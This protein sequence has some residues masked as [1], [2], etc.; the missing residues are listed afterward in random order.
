MSTDDAGDGMSTDDGRQETGLARIAFR[1]RDKPQAFLAR[2]IPFRIE[3]GGEEAVVAPGEP[4]MVPRG[5]VVVTAVVPYGRSRRFELTTGNDDVLEIPEDAGAIA[6][7][8][9]P[10]QEPTGQ[11]TGV[12]AVTGALAFN[13]SRW[14]QAP[15]PL[16]ESTG[17]RFERAGDLVRISSEGSPSAPARLVMA[18]KTTPAREMA[19]PLVAPGESAVINLAARRSWGAR[20]SLVPDELPPRLLLAYL[21]AGEYDIAGTMAR[22]LARAYGEAGTIRWAAPSFA[23]LIIGYA[24]A[25]NDERRALAAWCRRTDAARFLG[26]DGV[27]LAAE[28]AWQRRDR[29]EAA[30]LLANAAAMDPPV[31]SFGL[32]IGV[33]LAF[34][35]GASGGGG[36]I[37]FSR[38]EHG[39]QLARLATD[40]S[41]ISAR[42]D[43]QSVTV[44]RPQFARTPVSLAGR[45]WRRRAAWKLTYYL[46]RAGYRHRLNSSASG[47]SRSVNLD[48]GHRDRRLSESSSGATMD[49]LSAETPSAGSEISPAGSVVFKRPRAL[50]QWDT[51]V[52]YLALLFFAAW[53]ITLMV[54][55]V[56][57][58]V[59]KPEPLTSLFIVQPGVF[60][61]VGVAI[62]MAVVGRRTQELNRQLLAS[63]EL[64]RVREDEAL[65]GR[66][67]AA[68]LQAETT[69]A[70]EDSPVGRH[71]RMSK[72]LFGDLIGQPDGSHVMTS[73][74]T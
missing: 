43:P 13:A 69:D 8:A 25:L 27:I 57:E 72:A 60:V 62:T 39:E 5:P 7:L 29:Q 45:S 3:A 19:V 24:H 10:E 64:A 2:T 61:L 16:P 63:E 34:G 17:L 31:M 4:V 71:A 58:A 32:E 6:R 30:K 68:A 56:F 35:L 15:V 14:S 41:R 9:F 26:T 18:S 66:A 49:D 55:F 67:L 40:Y 21:D 50:S 65:K 1:W 51:L 47:T 59:G 46:T 53:L 48:R 22:A 11:A 54:T 12:T 42:S 33:S 28:L 20:P 38:L 74:S 36:Y 70:G 52:R 44:T 73:R 23:Q 37:D